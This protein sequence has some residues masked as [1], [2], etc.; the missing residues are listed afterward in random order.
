MYAAS[1]ADPT[2]FWA[3]EGQRIDWIK[4]Y[5]RVKD[6]NFKLGEVSASNGLKTAR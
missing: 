6:T 2:A 3:K 5:T 1:V 4:D